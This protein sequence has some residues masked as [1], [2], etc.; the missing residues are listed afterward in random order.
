MQERVIFA[1]LAVPLTAGAL[2]VRTRSASAAIRLRAFAIAAFVLAALFITSPLDPRIP[3]TEHMAFTLR[4]FLVPMLAACAVLTLR[5]RTLAGRGRP[6]SRAEAALIAALV[7]A[8]LLLATAIE[9]GETARVL[10][11]ALASP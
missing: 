10:R 7:A 5:R 3:H 1:V 2:G 6:P 4:G 9:P 8:C 11:A